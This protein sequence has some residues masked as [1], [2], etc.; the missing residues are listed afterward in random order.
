MRSP[1]VD[2]YIYEF[3]EDHILI[4]EILREMIFKNVPE[5]EENI[6]WKMPCYSF[7]GLLCYINKEKKSGK[8][9]LGFMEGFLLKDPYGVLNTDTS[10]IRKMS[11]I[12]LNDI[13]E[14][15]IIDFLK[16]SVEIN[17]TKKR[18]FLRTSKH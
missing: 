8:V 3:D 6:K 4:M 10:Q 1:A 12:S 7:K 11:F 14:E 16:Q 2:R 13:K 9:T 5:I 17:R 18:N 15:I